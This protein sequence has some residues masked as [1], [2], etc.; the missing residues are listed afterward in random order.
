MRWR[1]CRPGETSN[2]AIFVTEQ[3]ARENAVFN[4]MVA[5]QTNDQASA[6]YKRMTADEKALMWQSLSRAGW[7]TEVAP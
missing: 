7:R 4:A 6:R 1:W 5:R 3:D 2:S